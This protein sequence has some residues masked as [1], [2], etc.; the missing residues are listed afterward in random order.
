MAHVSYLE[1]DAAAEAIQPVYD[2]VAKSA[3]DMLN[4]FK[5]MAHSPYMLQAFLGLNGAL[6][7]KMK[8]DPK[9]RE[10]AYLKTS[11]LNE[12]DYCLHYHRQ[13]AAK[14]GVNERQIQEIKNFETSD[15]YDDREKA[16]LAFASDVTRHVRADDDV[17]ARVKEYLS[18][19]DLVELTLTVAMANFT[20]RVNE[21]L[22]IDLP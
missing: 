1:K 18:E 20:N 10:L 19:R 14:A 16:V 15:A 9:L 2:Q 8:L 5:A 4:M 13:S 12:C 3:G 7:G 21:A 11:D 6:G 22:A 17:L